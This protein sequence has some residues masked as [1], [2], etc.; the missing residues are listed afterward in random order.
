MSRLRSTKP[1]KERQEL[2]IG[3]S[4]LYGFPISRRTLASSIGSHDTL[5]AVAFPQGRTYFDTRPDLFHTLSVD[6]DARR[7]LSPSEADLTRFV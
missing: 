6:T 3:P 5:F 4:R 2:A 7:T 1:K